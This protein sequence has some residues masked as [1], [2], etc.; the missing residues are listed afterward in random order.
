MVE[1]YF[2]HT[3]LSQYIVHEHYVPYI[4]IKQTVSEGPALLAKM[5][6]QS[7]QSQC[8]QKDY[9][10]TGRRRDPCQKFD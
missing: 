6:S 1:S 7:Q 10:N 3:I 4:L 5:L 9:L 8:N 2:T